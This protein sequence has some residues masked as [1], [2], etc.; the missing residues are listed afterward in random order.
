M[1]SLACQSV[2]TSASHYKG[3]FSTLPSIFP[4]TRGRTASSSEYS[5]NSSIF[6]SGQKYLKKN[7]NKQTTKRMIRGRKC[8]GYFWSL[9]SNW[10]SSHKHR[11]LIH[12]GPISSYHS[13][14]LLLVK[15]ELDAGLCYSS[16][17]AIKA[18]SI[19]ESLVIRM[20]EKPINL[21][22]TTCPKQ[23]L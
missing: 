16:L 14:C 9:T 1:P 4:C 17:S 10:M 22:G 19:P 6:T 7:L 23:A 21:W 12:Q 13:K 2:F 18:Q 20:P 11:H 5:S 15:G 8:E 3:I